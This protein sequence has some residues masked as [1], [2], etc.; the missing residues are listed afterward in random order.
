MSSGSTLAP[1]LTPAANQ[2]SI[3]AQAQ[4]TYNAWSID[5]TWGYAIYAFWGVFYLSTFI[6]SA[7]GIPFQSFWKNL[8]NISIA[9]D[10]IFKLLGL[11]FHPSNQAYIWTMDN[12]WAYSFRRWIVDLF[13]GPI[14]WFTQSVPFAN[15]LLNIIPLVAYWFNAFVI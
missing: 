13:M 14:Q 4:A 6:F 1:G 9:A 5:T 7:V 8:A 3:T 11:G 2:P 12:W 15:W 10:G